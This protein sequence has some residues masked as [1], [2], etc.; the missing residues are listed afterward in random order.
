[1]IKKERYITNAKLKK[2]ILQS[3]KYLDNYNLEVG[4]YTTSEMEEKNRIIDTTLEVRIYNNNNY[5]DSISVVGITE[6]EKD[7]YKQKENHYKRLN[8]DKIKLKD[9]LSNFNFKDID[10]TL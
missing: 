7:Y 2:E 3:I 5:I 9:Y 4:Y 10:I 1:M 6:I 8:N